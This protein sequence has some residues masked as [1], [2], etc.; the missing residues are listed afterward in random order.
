MRCQKR[1]RGLLLS[2][3]LLHRIFAIGVIASLLKKN[4]DGGQRDE[5]NWFES[6]TDDERVLATVLPCLQS[7]EIVR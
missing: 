5:E 7:V 2:L 1:S 6:E 4:I 3:L